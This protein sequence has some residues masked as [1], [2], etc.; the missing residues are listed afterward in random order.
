MRREYLGNRT[1]AT[2]LVHLNA[3]EEGYE[4]VGV[5]SGFV[6]ILQAQEIG[7]ALG[8]AAK[9]Q[10]GQG[11][12]DV[13]AFVQSVAGPSYRAQQHQRNRSHLH[14]LA[15]GGVPRAVARGD[16]RNFMGHHAGK[17]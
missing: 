8:I 3:L 13:Q 7:F 1:G 9:L 10:I 14:Q 15:L 12:R 5:I 17:L 11:N 6:H 2:F 4:R 16:V